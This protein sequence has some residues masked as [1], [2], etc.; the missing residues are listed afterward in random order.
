MVLGEYAGGRRAAVGAFVMPNSPIDPETPLASFAVPLGA[1]EEVAGG[2]ISAGVFR[3]CK[4]LLATQQ[5]NS[6]P[7]GP[8]AGGR[9]CLLVWA[10]DAY[11]L[12]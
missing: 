12:T 11:C 2:A 8:G 5:R 9:G 10:A 4:L 6:Q 3:T 1:L 7:P